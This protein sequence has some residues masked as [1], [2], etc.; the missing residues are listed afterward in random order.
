MF[1][2][3]YADHA[4]DREVRGTKGKNHSASADFFLRPGAPCRGGRSLVLGLSPDRESAPGNQR[5]VQWKCGDC[6][7]GESKSAP[8]IWT[9]YRRYWAPTGNGVLDRRLCAG[10]GR[11]DSRLSPVRKLPYSENES[12][13]ARRS[14]NRRLARANAVAGMAAQRL[15]RSA[16]LP[17]VSY[18]RGRGTR[19]DYRAVW[20]AAQR[21]A[22]SR[23]LWR[24]LFHAAHSER[25]PRRSWRLRISA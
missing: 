5:L 21:H 25:P 9:I 10:A 2:L 20:H 12:A 6:W 15:S 8:R 3:S 24:E 14:R 13:G 22:P 18:A 1:D 11:S 16:Q 19:T 23:I 7:G 17:I 4:L